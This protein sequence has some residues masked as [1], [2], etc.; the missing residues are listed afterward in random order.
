MQTLVDD[1]VDWIR[2]RGIAQ[3]VATRYGLRSTKRGVAVPYLLNGQKTHEK[4]FLLPRGDQKATCYPTGVEQNHVWNVDCLKGEVDPRAV[5]FIT[6]GELDAL[7][8][9][10]AGA[11]Y[12]VSMPSGAASTDDGCLSKVRR[13][14]CDH[15]EGT[16]GYF[17]R[18]E[19]L[20]FKRYCI[21]VDRDADGKKLH[22]ALVDVL[23]EKHCLGV[24]YENGCKDANDILVKCG[25]KFLSGLIEDPAPVNGA[26]IM[27]FSLALKLPDPKQISLGAGFLEKRMCFS[28]PFFVTIG[29]AANSGKSTI[30][31]SLLMGL[32]AANP[33]FKASLFHGEGHYKIPVKR[34]ATWFRFHINSN[35]GDPEV[36]AQRDRWLDERLSFIN[37]PPEQLPYFDWLLDMI[38]M[39]ALNF[40]S[41]IIMIDPW[42]EI[43]HSRDMRG[44]LTDHVGDCIVRLKRLS[45]RLG[46]ILIVVHHIKKPGNSSDPPTMYDLADSAHWA[47]KSDQV[48]LAWRPSDAGQ[49]TRFELAKSKDFDLFGAPFVTWVNLNHKHFE[50]Y[51]VEPPEGYQ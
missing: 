41:K 29:G 11:Q 13:V 28:E 40:G 1:H 50:L 12:V 42:N 49:K 9:L 39:H 3:P 26:Y 36:Q 32:L 44:S 6:E 17:L 23:G 16:G 30:A 37:T 35:T 33:G 15:V 19:F 45:D 7:S 34:A 31:Q 27:P 18:D 4:I 25:Q 20:K 46:L 47:N 8:L 10:Q 24:P 22:K 43:L 51:E 48:L 38:E 5:L 2:S 14:F 21:M